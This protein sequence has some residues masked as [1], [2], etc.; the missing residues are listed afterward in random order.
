MDLE[1]CSCMFRRE[2]DFG[3]K[4]SN[5]RIWLEIFQHFIA[6]INGCFIIEIY[7]S[8]HIHRLEIE[9]KANALSSFFLVNF[10]KEKNFTPTFPLVHSCSKKKLKHNKKR[11]INYALIYALSGHCVLTFVFHG[12]LLASKG[13]MV[14]DSF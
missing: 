11:S 2:G 10:L 5:I 7:N 12:N 6:V 9:R 13:R 4:F 8:I 1:L 3:M 14:K